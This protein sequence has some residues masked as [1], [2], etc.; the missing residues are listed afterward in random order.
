VTW[1]RNKGA[2]N[3]LSCFCWFSQQTDRWCAMK[4][5]VPPPHPTGLNTLRPVWVRQKNIFH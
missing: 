2:L 3:Q 5:R 4:I 1:S